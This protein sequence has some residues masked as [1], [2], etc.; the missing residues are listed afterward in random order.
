MAMMRMAFAEIFW[1]KTK[2]KDTQYTYIT[3]RQHRLTYQN[4][5]SLKLDPDA[6]VVGGSIN[7]SFW[8]G[9]LYRKVQHLD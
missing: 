5:T 8:R 6:G 4:K 9:A 2:L 3:I 1:S 7:K